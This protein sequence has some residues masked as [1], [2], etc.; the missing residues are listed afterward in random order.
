MGGPAG[1]L[2]SHEEGR[3]LIKLAQRAGWRYDQTG[4]HHWRIFAPNLA[5]PITFSCTPGESV[6]MLRQTLAELKKAGVE[7]AIKERQ[8]DRKAGVRTRRRVGESELPKN[9]KFDPRRFAKAVADSRVELGLSQKELGALF[10]APQSRVSQVENVG[11]YSMDTVYAIQRVF[12]WADFYGEVMREDDAVEAPVA[13]TV[14]A[15]AA[16]PAESNGHAAAP[17]AVEETVPVE[18]AP[19]PR[20]R[21]RRLQTPKLPEEPVRPATVAEPAAVTTAVT[22]EP[23]ELEPYLKLMDAA[24]VLMSKMRELRQEL[25]ATRKDRDRWRARA[26]AGTGV[27]R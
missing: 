15:E 6:G 7:V 2:P 17:P 23:A 10:D 19:P 8:R 13:E 5:R 18:P 20:E 25:A 26:E 16:A 4:T 9:L 14:V 1:E 22:D 12:G 24:A 3:K 27:R 11:S 21:Q